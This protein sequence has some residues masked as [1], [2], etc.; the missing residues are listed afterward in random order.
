M[1][2]LKSEVSKFVEQVRTELVSYGFRLC[3]GRGKLVNGGGWRA[4]GYFCDR[5]RL[6]RV[7]RGRSDWLD[8]LIHEYAHF[9]QWVEQAAHVYNADAAASITVANYLHGGKTPAPAVLRRAFS[10]V[11]A[12]E[13]D[14]EMRAVR[15]AK[16]HGLP[17]DEERY[18]RHANLYIYSHH[19]MRDTGVW[20]AGSDPH[21]SW[22]I[23]DMMPS[24]F[25]A[26][27]HRSIPAPVYAA[28][29]RHFG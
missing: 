2:K 9:R 12:M 8:I 7:A 6:I 20:R 21:R 19:L 18:A 22:R 24:T 27:P 10:R 26:Q 23:V 3:F 13:R 4:A 17:I 1:G 14:A 11:M 5:E 29:S 25:K 28:L 16:A 15:I